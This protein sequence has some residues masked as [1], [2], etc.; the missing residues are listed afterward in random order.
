[1]ALGLSS[2]FL[3]PMAATNLSSVIISLGLLFEKNKTIKTI[4]DVFY[5]QNK[6]HSVNHSLRYYIEGPAMTEIFSHYVTNREDTEFWRHFKNRDNHPPIF[7][8]AYEES[9][10][11]DKFDYIK[12][13][14]MTDF[15]NHTMMTKLIG[16]NWFK[17][18]VIS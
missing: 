11:G 16:N 3:E 2:N 1:M 8:K 18:K 15:T 10:N 13:C 9:F 7:K 4:D 14:G 5:S 6:K 12:F 17:E